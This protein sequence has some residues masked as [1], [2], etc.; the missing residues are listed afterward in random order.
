MPMVRPNIHFTCDRC[1]CLLQAFSD[2]V[3][4]VRTTAYE[5]GWQRWEATAGVNRRLSAWWLCQS[6]SE[7]LL[8]AIADER[9]R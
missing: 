6:C 3:G 1:D 7:T 9:A 4:P 8:D 5:H 2:E